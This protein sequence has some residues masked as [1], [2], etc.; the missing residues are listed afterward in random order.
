MKLF[1][2]D[3]STSVFS[4]AIADK[5]TLLAEE[6]GVAGPSTAARLAPAVTG[7]FAAAGL[8]PADMDVFAVTVGPGA[9]TGL[10]VG[11]ALVKGLSCATGK[12][13]L[14]LSSLALLAMNAR[15]SDIP[16]CPLFDARK[17]EVYGAL[18]DFSV[19]STPVVSEAAAD[20]AAFL[21][22]I[23]G[24]ALFLGDGALRYR[25]LIEEVMGE[26]ARFAAGNLHHPRAAAG[27]DL[28]LEGVSK[29]MAI[30]PGQLLP[31]YLRLSEAELSRR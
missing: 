4:M 21:R 10:R 11:I 23:E 14:P 5:G 30:P 7:L 8:A 25:E 16:V 19:G 22:G 2:I 15:E 27:I 9:F 3:T 6:C 24:R 17:G 31:R 18:Y 1:I 29:G 20:P 28:A 12:P 13:A 26:R